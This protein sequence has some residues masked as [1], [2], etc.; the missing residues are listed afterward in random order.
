MVDKVIGHWYYGRTG[1]HEEDRA[2][3]AALYHEMGGANWTNSAN[4]LSDAHIGEWFGVATDADGR[5]IE[6]DLSDNGLSGQIPSRLGNLTNLRELLLNDNR[7]R[8]PIPPELGN[9]TNLARLELD[10]NELTG[11]I[12]SSLG[13]LANLTRLQIDDNM[14]T[15]DIPPSL[16]NLTNLTRLE[17][18]GNVMTGAIPASMG[19][20]AAL[21]YL[22]LAAGSRFAGCAPAGLT[23]VVDNDFADSGLPPC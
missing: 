3:L 21:R 23:A 5:V 18:D 20:L 10:D 11:T 16:G 8:G 2:E 12:P 4:W 6:L 9:L 1:T 14:L 13:N 15:G 7:L 17:L 22:R 19:N